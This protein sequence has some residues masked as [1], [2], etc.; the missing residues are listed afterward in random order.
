MSAPACLQPTIPGCD[1][2]SL[3]SGDVLNYV[4]ELLMWIPGNSAS[5]LRV[6][7]SALFEVW[8]MEIKT[9]VGASNKW[10]IPKT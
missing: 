5:S 7:I 8:S 6:Q 1:S 3:A 2:S 4:M 10:H 9:K